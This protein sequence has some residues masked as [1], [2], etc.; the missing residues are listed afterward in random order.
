M[1][2][3]MDE[4]TRILSFIFTDSVVIMRQLAINDGT[5]SIFMFSSTQV[6]SV[7]FGVARIYGNAIIYIHSNTFR[8]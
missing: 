5:C 3:A 8:L 4:S 2:T 7:D 1:V 6:C